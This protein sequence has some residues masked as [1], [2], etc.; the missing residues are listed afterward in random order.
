MAEA[1]SSHGSLWR[2]TFHRP[3]TYPTL[4]ADLETDVAI[5]GGGITGLTAAALLKRAGQRVAVLEAFSLGAGT[6]GASTCQMTTLLDTRYRDLVSRFGE[7]G[8]TLVLES[9]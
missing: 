8:A 6:T 1:T 3:R 4:S 7:P 2:E 5:V 9:A